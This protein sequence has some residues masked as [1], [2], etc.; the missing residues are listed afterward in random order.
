MRKALSPPHLAR[1][2]TNNQGLI[3]RILELHLTWVSNIYSI[4]I[5]YAYCTAGERESLKKNLE[6]SMMSSLMD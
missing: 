6:G 4:L 3:L 5:Y 1:S 2:W